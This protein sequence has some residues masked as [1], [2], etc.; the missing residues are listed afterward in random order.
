MLADEIPAAPFDIQ[1][2][3]GDIFDFDG[4]EIR[5]IDL[6]PAETI[7]ATGFYLPDSKTYVAGDQIYHKCHFYI[8]GG[9]NRPELWVESIKDVIAKCDINR[10]VPGHGAVGGL[11]IVERAIEYLENYAEIA[12]PLVPQPII[13]EAMLKRF[14]DYKMEGVLYMT[15]GPAITS[16]TILKETGGKLSFGHGRVV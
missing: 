14:P 11:E 7:H 1:P 15:R 3:T 16:P 6:K 5:L 12:K 13:I 8:G 9:L 10:I 2:L 4:Y